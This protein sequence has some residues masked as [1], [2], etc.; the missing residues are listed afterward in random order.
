LPETGL[1]TPVYNALDGYRL[2]TR[3]LAA[4]ISDMRKRLAK[5]VPCWNI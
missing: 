2:L 5:T 1:D 4:N 3:Q